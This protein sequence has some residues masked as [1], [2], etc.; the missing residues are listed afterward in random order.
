MAAQ[1][2]TAGPGDAAAVARLHADSWRR[3]YRGAYSDAYLDGDVLTDRLAV[4]SGRL[5]APEGTRTLLAEDGTEVLGFVHV[6]LDE[7][8]EWGTLVD[9][10]HVTSA[11][12]R[13]GVGRALLTR[14]AQEAVAGRAVP[15]AVPVGAGAERARPGVLQGAGRRPR[16]DDPRRR[17][18]GRPGPPERHTVQIPHVLARRDP[19]APCL[20]PRAARVSR[21]PGA[22]PT[23]PGTASGR[24][25]AACGGSRSAPRPAGRAGR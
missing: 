13:T 7:D 22:V 18:G 2:R 4:W 3:H 1:F 5:A 14:A 21:P 15:G 11:R 25:A 16:R 9:N 8:P 12:Q 10:L 17:P 24:P 6:V 20:R 19:P 23:P